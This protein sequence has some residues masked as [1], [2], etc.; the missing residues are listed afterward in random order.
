MKWSGRDVSGLFERVEKAKPSPDEFFSNSKTLF[1]NKTFIN[2]S[3]HTIFVSGCFFILGF[4]NTKTHFVYLILDRCYQINLVICIC[5]LT[6]QVIRSQ[7]IW[8]SIYTH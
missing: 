3:K 2:P 4:N 7:K 6:F 8:L 1:V 5:L